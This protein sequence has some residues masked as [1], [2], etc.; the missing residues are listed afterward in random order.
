MFRCSSRSDRDASQLLSVRVRHDGTIGKHEEALLTILRCLRKHQER[1]RNTLHARSRLD[2]LQCRT[3]DV[4][5]RI[6]RASDLTIRVARLNHQ[7]S[8]EQGIL[9]QDSRLLRSHALFLAQLEQQ[10]RI[11]R[12]LLMI[13]RIHNGCLLDMSQTET[14]SQAIN[15]SRVSNQNNVGYAIGQKTI[16]CL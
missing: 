6:L 5:R 1:A 9:N 14:L 7:A 15:L 10:V 12:L 11:S 2:D 13:L 3:Q 16:G 8:Q 4:A